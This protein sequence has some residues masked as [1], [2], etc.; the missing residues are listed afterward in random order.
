MIDINELTLG[1]IKQLKAAFGGEVGADHPYEIGA[2]YFIR[3][4][5]YHL[6]GRLVQVTNQELVIEDAAWIADD[7]RFAQAMEKGTFAEVEPFPSGQVIIGRGSLIDARKI[8]FELPRS[9]K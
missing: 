1:Q 5:T 7:G 9:Q 8:T 2:P 4:V 3:T 6:T